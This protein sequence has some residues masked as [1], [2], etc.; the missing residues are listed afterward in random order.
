MIKAGDR[1]E[2]QLYLSLFVVLHKSEIVSIY[3]STI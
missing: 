2:I 3:E 1:A